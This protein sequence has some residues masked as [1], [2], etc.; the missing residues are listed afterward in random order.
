MDDAVRQ[1]SSGT[2]DENT[3]NSLQG[4]RAVL[5]THDVRTVMA[6]DPLDSLRSLS[7]FLL[8]ARE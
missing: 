1:L 5:K 4:F 7:D 3:Y 8:H 2:F 6:Q